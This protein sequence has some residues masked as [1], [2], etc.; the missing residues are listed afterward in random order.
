[1]TS[2]FTD[3]KHN[4]PE[5][6]PLSEFGPFHIPNGAVWDRSNNNPT[7]DNGC[8]AVAYHPSGAVVLA[9]TKLNLDDQQPLYFTAP[10]WTAFLA[11]IR[12]GHI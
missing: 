6:P 7:N 4:Y 3:N 1:L 11:G 8:V 9:D 5:P 12:D 10:E 2:Y